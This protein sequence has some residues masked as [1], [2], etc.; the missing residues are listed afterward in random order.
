MI[1]EALADESFDFKHS[2]STLT[3][4]IIEGDYLYCANVGD[5]KA[6]LI[7]EQKKKFF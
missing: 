7:W 6:V 3:V 2:G 1:H 5:S 4:V